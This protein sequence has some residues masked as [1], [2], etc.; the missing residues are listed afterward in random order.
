MEQQKRIAVINDLAG[1]GKCA[2]SS[3]MPVISA[4]GV[5]CCPLPTAILST[6]AAFPG[7]FV[8]DYTE[9]MERFIEHW[10]QVGVEFDGVCCGFLASAKQIELVI[11]FLEQFKRP[12]TVVLLDPV[13]GDHGRLY[14]ASSPEVCEGMRRL[15]PYVDIVTPNLTEAYRLAGR[16]YPEGSVSDEYLAELGCELCAQ[17]PECI[18]FTGISRE[19]QLMNYIY[20]KEAD[21]VKVCVERVGGDRCGTG[22]VFAAIVSAGVVRGLSVEEAVGKAAE[23]LKKA[24]AYTNECG[25]PPRNGVCF[26]R[27]LHELYF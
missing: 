24:I 6:N 1:Y 3:A 4:M 11:R 27:F 26:E 25:T 14:S 10:E 12:E 23:F 15:L 8:D 19:N 22:D 21:P 9:Q 20:K 17:G 13:M 5:E 7:Y 2:L 16:E 18:I